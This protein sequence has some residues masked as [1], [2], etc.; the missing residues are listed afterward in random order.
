MQHVDLDALDEA[1]KTFVL[2]LS[3]EPRG[4]VLELNGRPIACMV[5]VPPDNGARTSEGWSEEQNARRC[6]LIDR[7]IAGTLSPEEAGEL[8]WLQEEMLRHRRRVA[9]LPLA[10]ARALHQEL[11]ARAQAGN[12]TEP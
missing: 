12:R 7:E 1:I 8:A 3:V 10:D 5:P 11:L 9:P 6:A 4:S 2:S